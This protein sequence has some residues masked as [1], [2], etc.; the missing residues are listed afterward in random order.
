MEPIMGVSLISVLFVL[1]VIGD[2]YLQTEK[3]SHKKKVSYSGVIIHALQYGIPYL[4]ALIFIRVNILIIFCFLLSVLAHFA[5][6]SLK[7][8]LNRKAACRC[9]FTRPAFVFTADQLLHIVLLIFIAMIYVKSNIPGRQVYFYGIW[10]DMLLVLK[11]LPVLA[12][13]WLLLILLIL[14]PANIIF[15]LFFSN[16]KPEAEGAEDEKQQRAGAIIGSL[17]RILIVFFISINQFSALG[18]IL[19][20]KSIARYDA[21]AKDRKFAEYY[22]IGTLVS[23]VFSVA[24]YTLVFKGL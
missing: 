5:V 17:E 14:K 6:D 3:I 19:T 22:L 9:F 10:N 7:Y 11:L 1:H 8:W 2:F 4:L 20:A 21:I 16:F 23:V 24:V 13:K 15:S 12:I 18:F